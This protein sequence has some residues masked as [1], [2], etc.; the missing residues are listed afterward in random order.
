M[1]G[2]AQIQGLREQHSSEDKTRFDQQYLLSSSPWTDLSLL[3]Q[4]IWTLAVRSASWPKP[5]DE[6]ESAATPAHPVR[7]ST[8]EEVLA[9]CGKTD[10]AT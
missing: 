10:G 9:G 1:T 7:L 6:T 8:E 4:T 3:L 2:L 5:G